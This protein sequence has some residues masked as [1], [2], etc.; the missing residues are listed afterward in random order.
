MKAATFTPDDLDLLD[1]IFAAKARE[2]YWAFRRYMNPG[3]KVGWWQ[4]EVAEELQQFAGQ[5][6]AGMRPAL[7]IQA[8]PQ[9]GKSYQIIDFLAWILGKHTVFPGSCGVFSH[10]PGLREVYGSFSERLGVRANLR[11]QRIFRSE[12]FLKVFPGFKLPVRGDGSLIN[13]EIIEIP[14]RESYFRNTTVAGSITGEGLDLGVIDDPIKG[15]KDASSPT[16]RDTAWN[17]MTDDLFT[18]FSDFGALLIILTRWHVDDPLGRLQE[19]MA[20]G[21]YSNLRILRYPA[22]AEEDEK[23]RK[24][25][26]ALFPEHKPKDFLLQRKALMLETSW[27][28]LYQ[29]APFVASGDMFPVT[30]FVVIDRAPDPSDIAESVRYWD[31]AGTKDGEGAETAGCLMHR[32]NDGSYVIS[33]LAHGRWAMLE[34]ERQ[35]RHTAEVDGYGVRVYIET[36]PG[37]AG[38]DITG[39]TVSNLA[40][41]VVM[42]DRPTGDKVV[43]AE[44]Y[45]S[46][47]QAGNV[48]IVRGEWNRPFLE[49]HEQFPNGK[50]K[51]MVD[52]SSGAFN[53]VCGGS[54]DIEALA[55]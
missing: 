38:K 20:R 9:H 24:A 53:K 45:A 6:F 32:M 40:G 50:L 31:K 23:H 30:K 1:R 39:Y 4:K 12:R 44:S 11:L 34:R 51:D 36:E 19:A 33:H 35:I 47:V 26:D 55:S 22:L 43:R 14:G 46:Q 17:W 16:V 15:R 18:R 37:S 10:E 41:F 13:R 29:Q 42:G 21:E 27:E 7:A 25:G 52:A 49:Q 48:S 54:Y 2:D 28:S 3:M 5:F 8:P